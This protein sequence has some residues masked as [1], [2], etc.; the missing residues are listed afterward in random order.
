VGK[1][2]SNLLKTF[3]TKFKSVVASGQSFAQR[4]HVQLRMC[5]TVFK[6]VFAIGLLVGVVAIN[7][8]PQDGNG[9][10]QVWEKNL[11]TGKIHW[12]YFALATLICAAS[13]LLTFVRWY[14]LVRAVGL[15][16]TL[17]DAL[18][19]GMV[20]FYFNT[21]L[22]GSVGGDI[23]KAAFLA[24]EQSRRTVAIATVIMDRLIG[25]WG[26]FWFVAVLGCVF[27]MAGMVPESA[28]QG[29]GWIVVVSV[30][31]VVVSVA[32]WGGLGF[33]PAAR[34]ERFA[35]RLTGLP[36]VG[37]S[38]AEFWRAV[39]MYRCQQRTVFLALAMSA[40]GFVGFVL[41]F[42]F[43]TLT[44]ADPNEIPTLAVHFLIVPI[45]L[46]I[47][48]VPLFPGGVGISE[49][50]FRGLYGM[51]GAASPS[52]AVLGS[53]VQRVV[54]WGLAL[55]GLIVYQRMR[56]ALKQ[57]AEKPV[58]AQGLAF[59]PAPTENG[60]SLE[61]AALPAQQGTAS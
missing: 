17:S 45:G 55:V 25:V 44:L 20:G 33:L 31:T 6:Y 24:Q 3:W 39:W 50:G 40:V 37:G 13:T 21:L 23:L 38:A 51:V 18:R 35:Q 52:N 1:P 46:L 19:L 60:H 11:L 36:K 5:W 14:V 15:P 42:Y 8:A 2:D 29:C 32:V 43:S 48:S 22:P 10:Q 58:V 41:T 54:S 53:L 26:L 16:F 4:Y 34:A 28:Q 56:P 27:W 61:P 59:P 30:I 57:V 9:L 12:E 7:W 47:A 49:L